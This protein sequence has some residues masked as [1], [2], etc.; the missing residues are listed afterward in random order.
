MRGRKNVP[1]IPPQKL[2]RRLCPRVHV[3]LL[4]NCPHAVAQR[5]D[6]N[7]ELIADL[8]VEVTFGQECEN[9]LLARPLP[10]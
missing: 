6:A 1:L 9:F 10:D 4:V 3:Q 2:D 5:V 8:F 7:A